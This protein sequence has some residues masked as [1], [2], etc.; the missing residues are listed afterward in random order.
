MA[1]LLFFLFSISGTGKII[2]KGFLCKID[3]KSCLTA[4]HTR[5]KIVPFGENANFFAENTEK[6]RLLT[7][8][9]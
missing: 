4:C 9:T 2:Q 8:E 6:F 1:D 3:K 5:S 7:A